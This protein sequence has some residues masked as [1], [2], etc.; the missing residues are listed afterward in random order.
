MELVHEVSLERGVVNE[1]NFRKTFEQ[2]MKDIESY[3]WRGEKQ[4]VS[5]GKLKD[6]MYKTSFQSKNYLNFNMLNEFV[7][8]HS[9]LR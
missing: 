9:R 7:R 6:N 4:S 8:A 3:T 1:R 2:R 5:T